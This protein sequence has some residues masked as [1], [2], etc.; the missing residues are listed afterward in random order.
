MD[1][2]T[3]GVNEERDDTAR[4]SV[5]QGSELGRDYYWVEDAS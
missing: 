2:R 4:F 3:E 1:D 5:D